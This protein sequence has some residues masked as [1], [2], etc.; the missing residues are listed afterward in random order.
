MLTLMILSHFKGTSPMTKQEL[1]AKVAELEERVAALE[2][3]EGCTDQDFFNDEHESPST[4]EVDWTKIAKEF[5]R[6][7][8]YPTGPTI[9]KWQALLVDGKWNANA[10]AFTDKVSEEFEPDSF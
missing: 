1:T 6:I 7:V 4:I 9:K 8:K 2:N 10:E 5:Y 3:A